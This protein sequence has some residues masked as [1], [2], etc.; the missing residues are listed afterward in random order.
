VA[1]SRFEGSLDPLVGH[2]RQ[3]ISR[4]FLATLRAAS[5]IDRATAI[6]LATSVVLGL[7]VGE[8]WYAHPS[9]SAVAMIAVVLVAGAIFVGVLGLTMGLFVLLVVTCIVDQWVFSVGRFNIRPEQIAVLTLLLVLGLRR[10]R[11]LTVRPTVAEILLLAWFAIGLIS[12]LTAAPDRSHSVKE[13]ALLALSSLAIFLPRR[14]LDR[15]QLD[16]VVRWVLLGLAVEGVYAVG[17]YFLH[18]FGPSI[19]LVVNPGTGHLVSTGTLWE[20]NV[21]GAMCGA[22][23]VG[24]AFLGKRYFSHPWVGVALCMSASIV[25]FTRAAWLAVIIVFA[26]CLATSI[27]RRM[28][29]N[30]LAKGAVATGVLSVAVLAVDKLGNY[31]PEAAGLLPS[32]GNATDVVGRVGQV[33]PVFA[34]LKRHPIFGGGIDSWPERYGFPQH[35]GNLELKIVNDTGLLGLLLLAAFAI[36]IVIGAWRVRHDLT[37]VA[38]GM[39]MLVLA[40]TNIATESLELMITWLLMGLLLAAIQTA[41]PV[42][43]PETARTA[44]GSGS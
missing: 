9:W 39:M 2:E 5:L 21:L 18:I 13:L 3:S 40:I 37:V 1:V 4:L 26:F 6:V 34:D 32:V 22:G 7:V 20:P 42:S 17:T 29:L 31:S 10:I 35:L 12:S 25:S 36:A 8:L 11:D 30:A 38:L 16:Q 24:W 14:L 28:D 44:P 33:T 23:A 41:A 15:E 27:R 43:Q 19:S